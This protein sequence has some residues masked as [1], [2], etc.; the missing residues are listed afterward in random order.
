MEKINAIFISHMHADHVTGLPGMLMLSSQV[1]R[2]EPLY[3]YGPAKLKEYIDQTRRLLDMYINYEIV[4][5][6]ADPGILVETDEYTIEAFP[7]YH[8]KPCVGYT[9]REKM[10]PGVFHP[11]KAIELGIPKGPMWSALQKGEDVIGEDGSRITPDMILGEK[12]EGRTFSYVTDTLYHPSI[13]SHVKNAD[14]LLC[15][16]MFDESLIESAIEK[17]HMTST[18]SAQIAYEAQVKKMGLFH[19]SPRYS[20][21]EL[22]LLLK[23]AQQIYANTFLAK[24]RDYIKL[25]LKD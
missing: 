9:M 5:K 24:D 21:K 12:R 23:E 3:I 1:D 22:K 6:T 20:N 15:E 16:G 2:T 25:E 7:L 10:R 18:Q 14:L 13:A 11:Q 19:Y 17:K 4:V 8:T